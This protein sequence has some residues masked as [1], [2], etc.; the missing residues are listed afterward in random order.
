MVLSLK[1]DF[2]PSRMFGDVPIHVRLLRMGGCNGHLVDEAIGVLLN[3]LRYTVLPTT[4]NYSAL[5]VTSAKA[6]KT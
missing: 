3:I 5:N 1:D 2:S 6:G 4:K